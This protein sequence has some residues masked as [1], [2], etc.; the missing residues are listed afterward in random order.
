[1]LLGSSSQLIVSG[2]YPLI[3]SVA[4]R[5]VDTDERNAVPGVVVRAARRVFGAEYKML[6]FAARAMASIV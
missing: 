6:I 5:Q 4:H 1:M 2:E 3:S